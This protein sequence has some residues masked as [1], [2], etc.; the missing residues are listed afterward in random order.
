MRR[1]RACSPKILFLGGAVISSLGG[2]CGRTSDDAISDAGSAGQAASSGVSGQ[3]GIGGASVDRGATEAGTT[4]KGDGGNATA[5]G[6]DDATNGGRASATDGEAGEGGSPAVNAGQS[7]ESNAEC[8]QGLCRFPDQVCASCV[9]HSNCADNEAC[10]GGACTKTSVCTSNADCAPGK[11][12]EP[13]WRRCVACTEDRDCGANAV[14]AGNAC[15]AITPC[16]NSLDCPTGVCDKAAARCVECVSSS[17]CHAGERCAA[18]ACV[19]APSCA[20]DKDCKA[21]KLLCDTSAGEC[22][23]CLDVV[24]CP[25]FHSCVSGRCEPARCE[26]GKSVCVNDAIAS[27]NAQGDGTSD[28]VACTAQEHCNYTSGV[29]HCGSCA[30]RPLDLIWAV[31]TNVSMAN[32]ALAYG[33]VID[34]VHQALKAQGVDIRTVLIGL[35][36]KN[37]PSTSCNM[38]HGLC[39]PPPTGS[40]SCPGQTPEFLHVSVSVNEDP[41]GAFLTT[42]PTWQPVLR[43]TAQKAFLV[44]ANRNDPKITTE[45]Q[46]T[47][48]IAGLNPPLGNTWALSG[49]VCATTTTCTGTL[50]CGPQNQTQVP[51][52][53]GNVPFVSLVQQS[54]GFAIDFCTT[55]ADEAAVPVTT[56]LLKS[57]TPSGCE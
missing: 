53:F 40:D 16:K 38:S 52:C 14:C 15:R 51:R 11:K 25:K 23:Q 13:M 50:L 41:L 27:C 18:N 39:V 30:K 29:P 47:S 28:G 4:A 2:A 49:V 33:P 6:G 45:V 48:G 43:S 3:T 26:P 55:S 5:S 12:C 19:A 8:G 44:V 22:V 17:D 21:A 34:R 37:P 24:D 1:A 46:F 42:Y 10:I 36:G 20:S 9:L 7:C 57:L 31:D 54:G 56:E 35:A 32:E